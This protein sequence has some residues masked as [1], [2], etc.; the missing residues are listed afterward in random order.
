MRGGSLR[1]TL[2]LTPAQL[3]ADPR[4]SLCPPC[5]CVRSSPTV[6]GSTADYS[7]RGAHCTSVVVKGRGAEFPK[8]GPFV[9]AC[10]GSR[11]S[12]FC[13]RQVLV[14]L[15]ESPCAHGRYAATRI[16]RVR[17]LLVLTAASCRLPP[18]QLLCVL[19][20]ICADHGQRRR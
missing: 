9:V 11:K 19:C 7:M 17:L 18:P 8:S 5:L 12:L 1:Q 10:D 13:I 15:R 3:P 6:L 16:L 2:A 20:P 14:S 4:P